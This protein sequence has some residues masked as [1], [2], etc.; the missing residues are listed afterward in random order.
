MQLEQMLA[1]WKR[2]EN[3]SSVAITRTNCLIH[4]CLRDL[5]HGGRW[6][7]CVSLLQARSCGLDPSTILGA[8]HAHHASKR[9][10]TSWTADSNEALCLQL[11]S[12]QFSGL[13]ATGYWLLIVLLVR[14]DVDSDALSAREKPV[15]NVFHPRFTYPVRPRAPRCSSGTTNLPVVCR[16]SASRRN[17]TDTRTFM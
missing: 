17:C 4:S 6:S 12:W 3:G 14:A 1:S 9:D 2:M 13:L 15:T 10:M 16:Y 7:S 5:G 11:G 8:H